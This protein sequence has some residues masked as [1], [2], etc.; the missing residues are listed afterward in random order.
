MRHDYC[1]SPEEKDKS[2]PTKNRISEK[3]LSPNR[4]STFQLDQTV[5]SSHFC[6]ILKKSLLLRPVTLLDVSILED[7]TPQVLAH[8][9]AISLNVVADIIFCIV[10]KSEIDL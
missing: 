7:Q 4:L 3:D 6:K 10:R 5:S 2:G 9:H 1:N 8:R